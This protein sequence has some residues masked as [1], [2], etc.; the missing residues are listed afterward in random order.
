MNKL[1]TGF[2]YKIDFGDGNI[3]VG[4]TAQKRLCFR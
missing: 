1:K 3:Y 4:K 2:I